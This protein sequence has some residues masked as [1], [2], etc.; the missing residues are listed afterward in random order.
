MVEKWEVKILMV[1][2]LTDAK[3]PKIMRPLSIIYLYALYQLSWLGTTRMKVLNPLPKSKQ[4]S[5]GVQ[6]GQQ[7][8]AMCNL[9]RVKSESGSFNV[10][11]ER[12]IDGY[13][14][15]R[16]LHHIITPNE[17][18]F[19]YL[20]EKL[21]ARVHGSYLN[22]S[23]SVLKIKPALL[24][25]S[26]KYFCSINGV[27][28]LTITLF[29]CKP[30]KDMFMDYKPKEVEGAKVSIN[31]AA[32][33]GYPEPDVHWIAAGNDISQ[34]AITMMKKLPNKTYQ[35]KS[36]VVVSAQKGVRYVCSIWN[37][38]I[39]NLLVDWVLPLPGIKVSIPYKE[40]T[41]IAGNSVE[42]I[43]EVFIPERDHVSIA[44]LGLYWFNK[45]SNSKEHLVYSFVNEE[46]NLIGQHPRYENRAFLYW[47]DFL[48]GSPDLKIKNVSI[49]DMGEYICR[50]KDKETIIGEDILELRVAA[51][52]SDPVMT[53]RR[54]NTTSFQ[55]VFLICHTKGG[56][57][58][59]SV[60]WLSSNG[61][62]LTSRSKTVMNL[63]NGYFSFKSGLHVSVTE[64]TRF[65][66]VISNP[67]LADNVSSTVTFIGD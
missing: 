66:C 48:R 7:F 52:Y 26:G 49:A 16:V 61:K 30:F 59:G 35:V 31:C 44:E 57:P 9:S 60:T 40:V 34:N 37:K 19:Q 28:S 25:D 46:E 24:E 45:D 58:L 32:K 3:I 67:W 53:Y 17:E 38:Y 42:L 13:T 6:V 65:T 23:I 20:T 47:E 33:E 43:C 63:S 1:D 39:E 50:V 15:E 55:D 62:D 5:V 12:T 2:R 4:S 27:K 54:N 36:S 51:P 8:T 41:G 18:V 64:G 21:K 29:V 56:F 14:L 22:A 11:W 10:E